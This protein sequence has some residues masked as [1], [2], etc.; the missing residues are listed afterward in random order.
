MKV[1]GRDWESELF[2]P[3][4]NSKLAVVGAIDFSP[5]ALPSNAV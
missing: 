2:V 3:G 1:L 5:V 4:R